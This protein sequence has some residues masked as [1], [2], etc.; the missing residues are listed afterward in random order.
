M[1]LAAAPLERK[2]LILC[3][4]GDARVPSQIHSRKRASSMLFEYRYTALAHRRIG[5]FT[6]SCTT[7]V[8]EKGRKRQESRGERCQRES[9]C[10]RLGVEIP[11]PSRSSNSWRTPRERRASFRAGR[12]VPGWPRLSREEA[13]PSRPFVSPFLPARFLAVAVD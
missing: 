4:L 3:S 2:G 5:T 10:L 11:S 9:R 7:A 8:V 12:E 13:L 6:R 1:P